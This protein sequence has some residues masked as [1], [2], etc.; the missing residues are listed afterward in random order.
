MDIFKRETYRVRAV[1]VVLLVISLA[2]AEIDGFLSG[3]TKD[4]S[5]EDEMFSREAVDVTDPTEFTA[6]N[7]RQ[8]LKND[9][10]SL[11]ESEMRFVVALLPSE[12]LEEKYE[13]STPPHPDD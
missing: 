3:E 8:T 10:M 1:V 9:L 4:N 13:R 5:F 11:F 6:K 7:P 12:T 2:R